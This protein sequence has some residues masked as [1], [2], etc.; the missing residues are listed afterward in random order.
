[1]TTHLLN[2][3]YRTQMLL[4][5]DLPVCSNQLVYKSVSVDSS[6]QMLVIV[7]T[8]RNISLVLTDPDGEWAATT[9]QYTDGV[10]NIWLFNGPQVGNWLFSFRSSAATQSCSYKI[11]QAMYHTPGRDTQMDLFW[12]TSINIDSDMGLPQPLFGLQHAIVMHLTNYPVGVPPERVQASLTISTNRNGKPTQVY[13][14][15]GIWRDVCNYNFY[16]PPFMCRRPNELFHFNFFAQDLLGFAVQRAGVM[17]CAEIAPPPTSLSGCQNGGVMNPT[18]TSCFCPPGFSGNLCEQVQCYNGGKYIGNQCSCPIGWTG[19][20]CELPKCIN[21]GLSPEF[22]LNQV[23]MVFM[24]ELTAQAHAQVVSLNMQFAEIIRDV[25]AQSRT[26]INRFYLVGFNSTWADIMAVS[27]SRDPHQVIDTLNRLAG[28][29]PTD[30]GCRVQLWRGFERL[31]R[32]DI[33]AGSYVEIFQTSP[34]ENGNLDFVGQLY[35]R[36]RSLFFKMNGFLSFTPTFKPDGFA[37]N[38]TQIIRVIPL[39]YQSALVYGQYSYK[40]KTPMKVILMQ[41]SNL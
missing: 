12:S 7:A 10:N 27:S 30:T 35:D 3:L 33:P 4:S 41:Y 22:I 2:T 39:Q 8:G 36:L 28:V 17:Y 40:C 20:F 16:F 6:I 24:V 26:W 37:C 19:T 29:I 13:A 5:N 15:N 18:N 25:Q 11:Y 9:E 34:E 38:A 14:S 31:L 21:K 1:M 32:W 23:D